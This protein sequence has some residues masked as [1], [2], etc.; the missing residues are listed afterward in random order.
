M[1]FALSA[2]NV[3]PT[4]TLSQSFCSL[5]NISTHAKFQDLSE[6]IFV[7]LGL[8]DLTKL[9]SNYWPNVTHEP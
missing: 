4:K 6:Y 7:I 2:L 5:T 3:I 9:E 8:R 1:S